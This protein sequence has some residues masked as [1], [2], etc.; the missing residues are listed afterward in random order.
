M[1][2]GGIKAVVWT[3]VVQ[4][5]ILVVG[6]AALAG[7]GSRRVGGAA[8]VWRIAVQT[9]RINVD[10]YARLHLHTPHQTTP[11]ALHRP[12]STRLQ[13][14]MCYTASHSSTADIPALTLS[15]SWYSIKR[16]RRDARL[17]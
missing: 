14:T 13:L 7:L 16:P 9:G 17:S 15:Q 2:Q 3:D 1:L 11:S 12:Y 5:L 8:A 4:M 6:L 10:E